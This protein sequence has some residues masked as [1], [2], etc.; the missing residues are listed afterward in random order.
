MRVLLALAAT[1]LLLTGLAVAGDTK[2]DLKKLEGT[3]KGEFEGKKLEMKMEKDKFTVTFSFG[4][5]DIVFKG[6]IK[7]D[8]SKK[9]KE[10]D[11]TVEE[12]K[13]FQGKTSQGIYEIDGDS[14]KWCAN[15]PGKDT[16]P[17]AFPDKEGETGEGHMYL[18]LKK[19]K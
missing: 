15:E 14:L 1:A 3:W 7:I 9:P 18:V 16:R 10:I 11:L 4:D 5:N 17:K 12:G 2:E 13:D 8:P 6:K 19:S